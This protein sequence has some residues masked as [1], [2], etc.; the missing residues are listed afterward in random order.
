VSAAS[1]TTALLASVQANSAASAIVARGI[2]NVL[3]TG[4]QA[5]SSAGS[6]HAVAGSDYVPDPRLTLTVQPD[7][8]ILTV[9]AD[10]HALV[11]PAESRTLLV[12]ASALQASVAP[13]F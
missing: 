5:S 2:A 4:A 10:P 6:I 3:I 12:T 11:V 8:R 13:S 1:I 9:L 7:P